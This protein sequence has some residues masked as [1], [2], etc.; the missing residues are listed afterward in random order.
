M[1]SATPTWPGQSALSEASL[2]R[3]TELVALL[4]KWNRAINLVAPSTLGDVW[5]RHVADSAQVFDLCPADARVWLDMGSGGGFPGLV[6]AILSAEKRPGLQVELVESDQRKCAF[7]QNAA[8]VLGLGAKVTRARIEDLAPRSA[9]VVSARALA[10]LP[11]LCGYALPNLAP[12]GVCLF[13]KGAGIAAEVEAARRSYR[14]DLT[15]F[16]SHTDPSGVVAQLSD[17]SH[18]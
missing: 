2:S 5:R 14:F 15:L 18:V 8:Q 12:H 10:A 4:G 7:L 13:L 1:T 17:L 9:D 16:P 3:L 11:V 6:V